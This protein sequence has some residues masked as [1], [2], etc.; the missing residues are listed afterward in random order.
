M[1]IKN[2]L[3]SATNPR[4]PVLSTV[5]QCESSSR[6]QWRYRSGFSPLSL[7]VSNL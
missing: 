3:N 6:L 2:K 7:S 4:L 5:A 1:L